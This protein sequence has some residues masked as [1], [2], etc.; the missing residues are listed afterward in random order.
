MDSEE[1]WRG[2]LD[3]RREPRDIDKEMKQRNR[4]IE[5]AWNRR[6]LA[7]RNADVP[8]QASEVNKVNLPTMDQLRTLREA[9]VFC[10]RLRFWKF[11]IDILRVLKF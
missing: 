1:Y 6:F 7:L 10:F 11:E 4:N 3:R 5:M 9:K 2:T 8:I